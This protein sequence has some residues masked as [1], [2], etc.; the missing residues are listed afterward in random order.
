MKVKGIEKNE[1]CNTGPGEAGIAVSI[2]IK[3]KF[4]AK[5][6]TKNKGHFTIGSLPQEDINFTF[7]WHL[8]T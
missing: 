3:I 8:S 7:L 5:S 1:P 4:K 2:A 6:V